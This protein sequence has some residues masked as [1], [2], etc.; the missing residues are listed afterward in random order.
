MFLGAPECPCLPALPVGINASQLA[1]YDASLNAASYGLGCATHDAGRAACSSPALRPECATQVPT[2]PGCDADI[3]PWCESE[4]CYVDASACSALSQ[5]STAYEDEGLYY[6]Y[7]ACGFSD[8]YSSSQVGNLLKNK[9]LRVLFFHNVAG[10]NGAFHPRGINNERSGD[11]YGT[12]MY[13]FA[14]LMLIHGHVPLL[15]LM[16]GH[17]HGQGH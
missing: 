1:A 15:M 8:A 5:H 6:S 14:L 4:W 3:P 13:G 17:E 7:A 11:Y 9:V 10:W 2:P 16:H 12:Y